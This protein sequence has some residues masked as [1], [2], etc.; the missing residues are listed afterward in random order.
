MKSLFSQHFSFTVIL[1]HVQGSSSLNDSVFSSV[2]EA[3]TWHCGFSWLGGNDCGQCHTIYGL[4]FISVAV[5]KSC[6]TFTHPL[7]VTT[8][9]LLKS[10][11]EV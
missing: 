3:L 7:L 5:P 2:A 4:I 9:F 11:Q 6:L 1:R 8:F 10:M